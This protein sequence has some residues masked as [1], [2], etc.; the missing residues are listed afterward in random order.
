MNAIFANPNPVHAQGDPQPRAAAHPARRCRVGSHL[1]APRALEEFN[2]LLARLHAGPLDQDQIASIARRLPPQRNADLAPDWIVRQMR[3]GTAIHLMLG[4]PGW[5]PAPEA[6]APARLVVS[7]LRSDRDL[8]PDDLPRL[9][10]LDDAIVVDAAWPLLADEVRDYLD[11]CR[12]RRIEA[13]LRGCRESEFA[14]GRQD[15]LR[16]R[17]AEAAWIAHRRA[18]GRRSYLPAAAAPGFRVC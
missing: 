15:W 7:Y 10:R 8:I 1:I 12:M 2:R 13:E 14:F 4:D 17:R 6:A 3:N 5:E 18:V 9:G 16:A 11:Y